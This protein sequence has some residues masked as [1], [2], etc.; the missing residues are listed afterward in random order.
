ML[1]LLIWKEAVF[2]MR[3]MKRGIII[4]IVA[5]FVVSVV[6]FVLQQRELAVKYSEAVSYAEKGDYERAYELMNAMGTYR[7]SEELLQQYQNEINYQKATSYYAEGKYDEAIELFGQLALEGKGYKDSIDLQNEVE[8][9]KAVVLEGE[10]NLTEALAVFNSLPRSYADVSERIEE[11]GYATKF[12]DKWYCK[13]HSIDLII[14]GR[15]SE[16]NVT[17]LDVEIKDRNGFLLGDETNKLKGKNIVLSEDRFT[18]DMFGDGVKYAVQLRD[19][20]IRFSKQP[21]TEE[22]NIVTFVRKLQN[23]VNE[24]DGDINADVNRSVDAGV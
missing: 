14:K 17:Y 16:E 4:S 1:L 2:K 11:I 23:N 12:I 24:V 9:K 3:K 21:V 7:D 19:N 5:V 18:W 6:L 22:S 15:I 10:G 13:E 20:K 8:Y